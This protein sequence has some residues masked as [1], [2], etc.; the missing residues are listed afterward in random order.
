M[1]KFIP[2]I[3]IWEVSFLDDDDGRCYHSV[4]F[5]FYKGAKRYF[6]RKI[7]EGFRLCLGGEPLYFW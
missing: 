5:L 6:E 4:Y 2:R 1:K 7:K 3:T